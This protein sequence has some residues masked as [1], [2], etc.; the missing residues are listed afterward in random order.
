MKIFNHPHDRQRVF[1]MVGLFIGFIF[2][3][4]PWIVGSIEEAGFLGQPLHAVETA[5]YQVDVKTKMI[6]VIGMDIIKE[7]LEDLGLG[8]DAASQFQTLIVV[9]LRT[10]TFS[11]SPTRKAQRTVIFPS[12]TS[13]LIGGIGSATPEVEPTRTSTPSS[14]SWWPGGGNR[15]WIPPTATPT[16]APTRTPTNTATNTATMTATSTPTLTPSPTLTS[17]STSTVMPTPTPTPTDTATFIPTF[18]YT[19][20]P[21]MAPTVTNTLEPTMTPSMTLTEVP[22]L[23]VTPTYTSTPEVK[24]FLQSDLSVTYIVLDDGPQIQIL[25]WLKTV[26]ERLK[27]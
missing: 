26:H 22:T 24:R 2:L 12:A 20:S 6:P 13:D 14:T 25:Q 17:T 19:P 9:T 10:P 3:V 8:D 1:L 23:P 21:T 11:P 18:T 4:A 5:S 16:Q 7:A 27:N 15:T